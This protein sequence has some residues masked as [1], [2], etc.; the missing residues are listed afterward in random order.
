MVVL[1]NAFINNI[2][3]FKIHFSN[4]LWL[5]MVIGTHGGKD[6]SPTPVPI[7]VTGLHSLF[8][9]GIKILVDIHEFMQKNLKK[10]KREQLY[11]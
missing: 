10:R 6:M 2:D 5:E 11:I 9:V 1:G 8:S 3:A 4:L 7:P